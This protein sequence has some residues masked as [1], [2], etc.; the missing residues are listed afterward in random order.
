METKDYEICFKEPGYGFTF[1]AKFGNCK[2]VTLEEAVNAIADYQSNVI[3]SSGFRPFTCHYGTKFYS[4]VERDEMIIGF[5]GKKEMPAIEN[6]K[7]RTY[8]AFIRIKST[9]GNI[10]DLNRAIAK[11][12]FKPFQEQNETPSLHEDYMDYWDELA[13]EGNQPKPEPQKTVTS[14]FYVKHSDALEYPDEDITDKLRVS[15]SR[16]QP[17]QKPNDNDIYD[18]YPI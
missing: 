10:S 16:K 13:K 12:F 11:R 18:G 8:R 15:K 3:D 14:H 5:E 1:F 2:K 7:E 6:P 4:E 9:D 17:K